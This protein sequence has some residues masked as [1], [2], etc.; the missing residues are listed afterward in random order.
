MRVRGNQQPAGAF[1][2]YPQP[3]KAGFV[4]VRFFENAHKVK[5]SVDDGD[6]IEFWEYD[7]YELIAPDAPDLA[8]DIE[9]N[10][11]NWLLTAKSHNPEA[12][13]AA[14]H[15]AE[16]A[17]LRQA[18]QILSGIDLSGI[19]V[20]SLEAVDAAPF[21]AFAESAVRTRGL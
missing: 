9:A 6:P 20:L 4:C 17:D 3:D 13:A 18:V 12:V 7:E 16:V 21:S 15:A 19:E 11:N 2:I 5:V 1:N 10:Y 8:A 14:A